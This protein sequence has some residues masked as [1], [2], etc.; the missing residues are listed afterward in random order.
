MGNN[1]VPYTTLRVSRFVRCALVVVLRAVLR[2]CLEVADPE[3]GKAVE[4][5]GCKTFRNGWKGARGPTILKIL[6]ITFFAKPIN[7]YNFI[8]LSLCNTKPE[9]SKV[10]DE[11]EGKGERRKRG[12]SQLLH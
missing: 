2:K 8:T 7:K 10:K 12:E 4:G 11:K 9:E 6:K 1:A 5:A 3:D